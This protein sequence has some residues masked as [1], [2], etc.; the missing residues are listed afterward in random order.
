MIDESLMYKNCSL[1]SLLDPVTWRRICPFLTCNV[2]SSAE[3]AEEYLPESSDCINPN[4]A[5]PAFELLQ[6]RGYFQIGQSQFASKNHS[7]VMQCLARGVMELMKYGYSP[8]FLLMYNESWMIASIIQRFM[9]PACGGI[10]SSIGDFYIF[11]VLS[12][13]EMLVNTLK[14]DSYQSKYTPGPPHRDRPTAGPS[15]F[16]G[17]A[18]CYCSVWLALTDA[19]THNSCLYVVPIEKDNGYYL[20]GD[21]TSVSPSSHVSIRLEDSIAK[22]LRAGAMLAFSHRLLHWGSSIEKE[23]EPSDTLASP[24]EDAHISADLPRI[25]FTTAFASDSFERPYYCHSTYPQNSSTPLELRLGLACGQ[26][27]QYEHLAP[28]LKYDLAL[29]RRIFH[30]QKKFF[31]AEYYEKISSAS[32]MLAF[33]KRS[34]RTMNP[35]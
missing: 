24:S 8:L 16:D 23:P 3:A 11:A 20:S 2:I 22:P 26:Q 31:N 34:E 35:S 19:T 25:A 9:R 10:N 13:S 21:P 29:V 27:I 28:L 15:S 18:P 32:Q 30:A 5:V 17:T 12:E 1:C 14:I 6:S 4:L 7:E 33:M